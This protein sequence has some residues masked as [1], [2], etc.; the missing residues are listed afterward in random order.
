M[1]T[2]LDINF[3][4]IENRKLVKS[5]WVCLAIKGFIETVCTS[6]AIHRHTGQVFCRRAGLHFARIKGAKISENVIF[7]EKV[8]KRETNLS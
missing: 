2:N 1:S 3:L 8:L 5:R 4:C 7:A 6:L